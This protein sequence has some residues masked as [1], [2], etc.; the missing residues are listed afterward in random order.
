MSGSAKL[1]DIAIVG[2]GIVGV[3]LA[4]ALKATGMKIAIIEAQP[5]EIAAS[6]R[7]SYA[8]SIMSSRILQGVGV[9]GDIFPHIG[10]FTHIRL[11]DNDYPT[12]VPF[13]TEDLKTDYLGYVGEHRVILQSL[14]KFTGDSDNID[15]LCPAQV[16]EVTYAAGK[17]TITLNIDGQTQILE[18]KLVVG[19]DGAKSQIRQWAGIKTRGW[20]YWQS[21][22]TFTLKHNL[23]ANDTAFERFCATGPM[24]ILPLPENRFQIVWTAPHATAQSLQRLNDEEFLNQLT[25]HTGGVL[26]EVELV[27]PRVLFPVQLMQCDRYTGSRLALIGDAAHCC[28][29]VGGQGLNLGIRDAA[30]LA[31]VLIEARAKGED[32]GDLAV[33]KRYDSWRKRENLAILGFTDMLDRMFSSHWLP[34]IIIRRLGLNMMRHIPLLKRFALRLMTGLKGRIPRLALTP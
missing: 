28:H 3:T 32:I 4:A 29:P 30:A 13:I 24:G 25:H 21:C 8:L 26:G 20:K 12:S 33:L 1:Y 34:V 17:A 22:V 15:W 5:P 2:G 7:Q 23:P 18:T 19:A 6:R 11:S 10:K 9:W 14:Q 27:S 16:E 31:Q